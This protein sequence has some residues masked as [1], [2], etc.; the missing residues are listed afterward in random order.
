MLKETLLFSWAGRGWGKQLLATWIYMDLDVALWLNWKK[1]FC[2][3]LL[4]AS[5]F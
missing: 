5:N 2:R 1:P 4:Q 3:L